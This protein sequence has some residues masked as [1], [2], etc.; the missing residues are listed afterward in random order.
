MQIYDK[1]LITHNKALPKLQKT[2]LPPLKS[3]GDFKSSS[4]ANSNRGGGAERRRGPVN[5]R[6]HFGCIASPAMLVCGSNDDSS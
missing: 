3:G 1:S 2:P 6:T 4:V 5:H